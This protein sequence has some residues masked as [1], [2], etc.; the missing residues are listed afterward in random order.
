MELRDRIAGD[1]REQQRTISAFLGEVLDDWER[2]QR[3]EAVGRA[4]RDSP[5][6]DAYW[7]ESAVI[8]SIGGALDE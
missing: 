1:A 6:D 3:M 8:D 4:M 7:T 5:P 2:R